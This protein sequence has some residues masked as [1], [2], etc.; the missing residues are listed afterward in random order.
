MCIDSMIN[1]AAGQ[2]AWDL[3]AA[4]LN[5]ERNIFVGD[6]GKCCASTNVRRANLTWESGARLLRDVISASR[7]GRSFP[8]NDGKA[9]GAEGCKDMES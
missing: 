8:A 7:V 5:W 4:V 1:Q 3:K 6:T 9:C 2:S